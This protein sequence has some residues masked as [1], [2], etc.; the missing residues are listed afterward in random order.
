M[1]VLETNLLGWLYL[2]SMQYFTQ[3]YLQTVFERHR[4]SPTGSFVFFKRSEEAVTT[5]LWH[6]FVSGVPMESLSA[7][8]NSFTV[9]LYKKLNETSKGQNI[10]FSPW[11]IATAL[12]MVHLGAKGDTATQLAEVSSVISCVPPHRGFYI[13]WTVILPMENSKE[14]HRRTVICN[15]DSMRGA[16]FWPTLWQVTSTLFPRSLLF[17]NPTFSSQSTASGLPRSYWH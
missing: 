16:L 8:T 17:T 1:Q 7:S 15:A 14:Q 6:S 5:S 3:G 12:A 9:D 11:S 4:Q 10:F 2:V 13:N